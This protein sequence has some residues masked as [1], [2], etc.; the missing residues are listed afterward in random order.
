[1]EHFEQMWARQGVSSPRIIS[2]NSSSSISRDIMTFTKKKYTLKC[3]I[4]RGSNKRGVA[5]N[6]KF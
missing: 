4:D 6:S 1:M 3:Q 2:N 5:K